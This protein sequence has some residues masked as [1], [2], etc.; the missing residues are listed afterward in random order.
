MLGR[1]YTN[2][3]HSIDMN[4]FDSKFA[5]GD[6]S[7]IYGQTLLKDYLEGSDLLVGNLE[8]AITDTN[9]KFPKTFNYRIREEH[10][11]FVKLNRNQYM[12]IANNHILDYKEQGMYDTMNYLRKMDIK[13]SGADKNIQE[14]MKYATFNIKGKVIGILGCADHYD[15]WKAG[16]TSPGIFLVD[17]KDYSY[18]EK[19]VRSI[20][21]NVDFLILSIHWGS[22]YKRG[23]ETKYE[24][25]A[26]T[27]L[28]AGVDIIHGH[29]SHHVKC[30]RQNG[31]KMIIY[32]MGDF[33]NDYAI[34][35]KYRNDLGMVVKV[36]INSNKFNVSII[37]TQI[38]DRRVDI[39]TDKKNRQK[40]I[41]MV[42][43]DCDI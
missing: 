28:N 25:F 6:K 11:K 24:K 41:D 21:Q 42:H 4:T 40:I 14:A 33:V 37:P 7:Q 1:D 3:L 13:F 35:P 12:S 17:Y 36:I 26:K 10:M 30:I 22:N 31:K 2:I 18:I 8:T 34:D 39:I 27:M 38:V 32:G 43:N 16:S 23:V 29:S 15:Y 5:T 20:K 9:D 19:Y